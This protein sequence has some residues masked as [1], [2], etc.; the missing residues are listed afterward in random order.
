MEKV[1]QELFWAHFL[2]RPYRSHGTKIHLDAALT[3]LDT[4]EN[5]RKTSLEISLLLGNE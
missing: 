3:V 2:R 1:L 5:S 4:S